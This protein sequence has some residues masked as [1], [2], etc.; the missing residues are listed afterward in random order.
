EGPSEYFSA[1]SEETGVQLIVV[2]KAER[3]VDALDQLFLV[4]GS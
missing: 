3:I 2:D 4:G 1:L